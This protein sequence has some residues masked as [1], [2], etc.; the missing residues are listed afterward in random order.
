MSTIQQIISST[1]HRH[2]E[3]EGFQVINIKRAGGSALLTLKF[4]KNKSKNALMLL[5][6]Y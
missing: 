2:E 6:V 5:S 1:E 4:K 3:E